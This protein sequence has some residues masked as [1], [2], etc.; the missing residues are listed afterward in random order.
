MREKTPPPETEWTSE[1][2]A[3]IKELFFRQ[4]ARTKLSLHKA[5]LAPLLSHWG[6]DGSDISIERFFVEA[7]ENQ[8]DVYGFNEFKNL[9]IKTESF[10]AAAARASPI[11]KSSVLSALRYLPKSRIEAAVESF[12]EATRHT[13]GIMN[14]GQLRTFFYTKMGVPLERMDAIPKDIAYFDVND[15][16]AITIRILN[17]KKRDL[18]PQNV[19]LDETHLM[20]WAALKKAGWTVEMLKDTWTYQMFMEKGMTIAEM[21]PAFTVEELKANGWTGENAIEQGVPLE[22]CIDNFS[23]RE[24]YSLCGFTDVES[25]ME[26]RERGFSLESLKRAGYPCCTCKDAG[27][28]NI[29]LRLAGYSNQVLALTPRLTPATPRVTL[30]PRKK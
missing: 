27:F 12:N 29:T 18:G 17:L 25:V 28:S 21:I 24:L 16:L 6:I 23:L 26:L 3:E 9:V 5:D 8:N 7:D 20:P 13:R 14:Y 30:T 1:K 2:I 10:T 11:T 22:N 19:S 4:Q 15:L